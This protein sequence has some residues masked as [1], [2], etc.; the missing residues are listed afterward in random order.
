MVGRIWRKVWRGGL[1]S[2]W[3]AWPLWWIRAA[4]WRHSILEPLAH[5]RSAHRTCAFDGGRREIRSRTNRGG[6]GDSCAV[7]RR[8]HD[9]RQ[10][11]RGAFASQFVGQ[12]PGGGAVDHSQQRV[13]AFLWNAEHVAAGIIPAANGAS[14]AV[15]AAKSR[16][17]G[18]GW[19][20]QQQRDGISRCIRVSRDVIC[21]GREAE[22]GHACCRP[23]DEQCCEQERRESGE[24]GVFR[25]PRRA[26]VGQPGRT[27]SRRGEDV[28]ATVAQQRVGQARREK[29]PD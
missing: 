27:E 21:G 5:K 4:A 11:P 16:Q 29:R 14:A 2:V 3:W 6:G 26:V 24:C 12:W 20:A 13:A 9:D 10:S 23:G 8:S 22:C 15:Y 25:K 18:D 28:Y 1:Q 17:R 7:K 19:R